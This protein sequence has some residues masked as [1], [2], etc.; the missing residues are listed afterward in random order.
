M[1]KLNDWFKILI[2]GAGLALVELMATCSP[3]PK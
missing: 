2:F 3:P 1:K